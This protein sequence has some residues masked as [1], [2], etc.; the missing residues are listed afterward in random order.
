MLEGASSLRVSIER[1]RSRED[2][3]FEKTGGVKPFERGSLKSRSRTSQ[4]KCQ[5][6]VI[7]LLVFNSV[8][9]QCSNSHILNNAR[10]SIMNLGSLFIF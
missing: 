2:E 3:G 10:S 1:K 8:I 6:Y 5:V 9:G 4:E 7:I